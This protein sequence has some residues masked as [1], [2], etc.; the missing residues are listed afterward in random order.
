MVCRLVYVKDV[1]MSS[2]GEAESAGVAPPQPG[3]SQTELPT[4]PVCL[5][6]LDEETSGL[7]TTVR[8]PPQPCSCHLMPHPAPGCSLALAGRWTGWSAASPLLLPQPHSG[9]SKGG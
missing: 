6:R 2:C 8:T 7:V 9:A 1:Q 3:A 4:C 5:D